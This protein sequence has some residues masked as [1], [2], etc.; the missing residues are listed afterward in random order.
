MTLTDVLKRSQKYFVRTFGR[1]HHLEPKALLT[2]NRKDIEYRIDFLSKVVHGDQDWHDTKYYYFIGDSRRGIDVDA[3][4]M[5]RHFIDL[6][7]DIRQNGINTPLRAGRYY[8]DRINTR[9]RFEGVQ[10]DDEIRNETGYQLIEGA[11]R[12]AIAID[13][14]LESVPANVHR[15]PIFDVPN[16]TAYI[17]TV[18]NEYVGQIHCDS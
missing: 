12:L 4:R 7:D 14:S 17:D 11:H 9:Y 6:H 13:L 10:Y 5:C 2:P 3:D 1:V 15:L 16:Y 18:E 8:Q